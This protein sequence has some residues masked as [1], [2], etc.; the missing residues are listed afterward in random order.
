MAD[1]DL[2]GAL[3]NLTVP[4]LVMCGEAD[5]LTPPSHARRIAELLPGTSQLVELPATGH[6]G[7]LERPEEV[8][9]LLRE[10]AARAVTAAGPPPPAGAQKTGRS[11]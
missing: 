9:A 11:R 4:A 3:P 6:M 5:K 7:P 10:L 2:S 8:N 1:M